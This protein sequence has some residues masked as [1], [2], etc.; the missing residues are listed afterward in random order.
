[1]CRNQDF[2]PVLTTI[3]FFLVG[4]KDLKGSS[5]ASLESDKGHGEEPV[6]VNKHEVSRTQHDGG[7]SNLKVSSSKNP[8]L[9]PTPSLRNFKQQPAPSA[10]ARVREE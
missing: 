5:S 2:T 4:G 1:M 9:D 3:W 7:R 10:R 6:S 8:S